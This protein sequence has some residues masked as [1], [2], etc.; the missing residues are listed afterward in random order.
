MRFRFILPAILVGALASCS[1]PSTPTG[2]GPVS[3]AGAKL[4][5]AQFGST[6]TIPTF[7]T[8]PAQIEASIGR[9][10][11]EADA[12]LDKVGKL[13][14]GEVT[15]DNTIRALDDIGHRAM[16]VANR[17]YLLKETSQSAEL[18]DAGTEGI[19][20]FEAWSVGLDYRE[21]VYRAVQAYADTQP[22]LEGERKKLFDETLRDYKRAGLHLAKAE[23]D[24]VEALR[25]KLAGMT[26]D[27]RTN[28]TNEKETVEFSGA[29]L[30]G[31]PE[32][33]L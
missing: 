17:V 2:K 20:R 13:K 26:T 30:E 33:F 9:A 28:I 3:F 4:R 1:T 5:A 14:A 25:K 19:K 11:A 8:R 6:L 24:K 18:R 7:E 10:I 27:F 31:V 21:D 29:D 12:A 16:T 15:F 23:R 22:Q 32:S